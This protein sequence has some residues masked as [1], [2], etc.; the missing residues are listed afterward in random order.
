FSLPKA[1]FPAVRAA[2]LPLLKSKEVETRLVAAC[3]FAKFDDLAAARPLIAFL[4]EKSAPPNG[5]WR[6]MQAIS[7]L[8]GQT[9]GYDIHHWGPDNK[10]NLLAIDKFQQ[11]LADHT[12]AN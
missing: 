10:Q 11:W 12:A 5:D 7:K 3:G 8:A 2:L 4:G 1:S 9:F 6:I